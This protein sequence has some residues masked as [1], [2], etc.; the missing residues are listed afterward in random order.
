MTL[1]ALTPDFGAIGLLA[2]G[3]NR[4]QSGSLG[5]L[6]TWALVEIEYGGRPDAELRPLWNAQLLDRLAG[7]DHDP[8]RLAAA[9][10]LAEIAEDAAPPGHP[11]PGIFLWLTDCLRRL[12]AL[13]EGE[14]PTPELVRALT[15][16]LN[17]LGLAPTLAEQSGPGSDWFSP[18]GGGLL[19]SAI[20]PREHARRP[21]AGALALLRRLAT[22][23]A[24]GSESPADASEPWDECFTILGDLLHSHMERQPRAWPLLQERRRRRRSRAHSV[25]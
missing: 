15:Q 2:K 3:V 6:D 22:A 5:V 8:E 1:R 25:R 11:A 21:S 16:G 4:L 12:S 17:L 14:D 9:A 10:V 7:L 18:A 13:P 23:P 24:S 20:R 19:R